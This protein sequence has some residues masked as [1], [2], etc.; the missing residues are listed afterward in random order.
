MAV[1]GNRSWSASG[2]SPF[3][4]NYVANGYRLRSPFRH[5]DDADFIE[6]CADD[7]RNV[8]ETCTAGSV[9]CLIAEPIQGVGGFCIPPDGFFAATKKVLDETG[10]LFISD[11]VQTGWGRTGEHFW[12]Y[13]AHGIVPDALT[14]AKGLGNGLAIGG[15]VARG[16][17]MDCVGANSISTFGGNPVATSGALANL[18][19]LLDH[20][21]QGNALRIGTYLLERLRPLHDRFE[22]VAEVRGR[23]LMV[24]VEL[25]EPDGHTPAPAAAAAILEATREGGLLIGKG[26]LYGNCLRISPPLTVTLEEADEGAGILEAAVA[27]VARGGY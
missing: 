27:M 9:A 17:L 10:I 13:Q 15:V 6:A 5:L 8:I 20:D 19:Y 26:G 12:G 21:L 16:E 7:V 1:T 18:R 2:L 11:E 3:V 14:F 23:G 25:V 4:V 22:L 24:G